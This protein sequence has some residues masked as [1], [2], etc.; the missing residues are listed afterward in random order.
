MTV[1]G[2]G[3][4]RWVWTWLVAVSLTMAVLIVGIGGVTAY[5]AI[6]RQQR[7]EAG[8]REQRCIAEIQGVFFGHIAHVFTAPPEQ[9]AFIAKQIEADG[10]K[11]RHVGRYC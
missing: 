11:L 4:P 7:I 8:E 3:P 1:I 10:V 2:E 9:R 5:T 6:E